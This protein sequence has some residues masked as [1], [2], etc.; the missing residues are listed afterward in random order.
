[1][2]VIKKY[3]CD[4]RNCIVLLPCSGL[5]WP[6]EAL[7]LQPIPFLRS[8]TP[9][10]ETPSWSW[11]WSELTWLL[12][13]SVTPSSEVPPLTHQNSPSWTK[14]NSWSTK[15]YKCL[16]MYRYWPHNSQTFLLLPCTYEKTE[17]R[18]EFHTPVC[19]PPDRRPQHWRTL[20][21]RVVGEPIHTFDRVFMFFHQMNMYQT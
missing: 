15:I 1:M 10:D 19:F 14:V 16:T 6:R 18:S 7:A 9:G 20:G 17:F 8:R 3:A 5:A 2:I 4:Q 13:R 12:E 21:P 11:S